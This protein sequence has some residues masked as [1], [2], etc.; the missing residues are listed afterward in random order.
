VAIYTSTLSMPLLG[1]SPD[2]IL[3]GVRAA[4]SDDPRVQAMRDELEHPDED[5]PTEHVSVEV[6]FSAESSEAAQQIA[7]ELH[8]A[9][10]RGVL[11]LVPPDDLGGWTSSVEHPDAATE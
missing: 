4:L 6:R 11:A 10:L 3:S 2:A 5:A 7:S 9:A 1:E 8:D